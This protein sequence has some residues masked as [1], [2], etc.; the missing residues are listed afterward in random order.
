MNRCA[1]NIIKTMNHKRIYF[2]SA[3]VFVLVAFFLLIY[4]QH[5]FIISW[6]FELV[7]FIIWGFWG[8]EYVDFYDKHFSIVNQFRIKINYNYDE[9]VYLSGSKRTRVTFLYAQSFTLFLCFIVA[10]VT[11]IH[12]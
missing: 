5:G 8:I 11:L 4:S 7:I 2:D 6:K 9:F 10:I 3:S 12:S 1:V